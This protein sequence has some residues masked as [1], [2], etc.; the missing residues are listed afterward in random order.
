MTTPEY[1][2]A[3]LTPDCERTP[4]QHRG[5]QGPNEGV[6]WC[7]KHNLPDHSMRPLD[8]TFGEHLD[9]CSLPIDHESYCV[10]GGAG[11][12]PATK[13]RGYFPPENKT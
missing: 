5:P 7:Y 9:D 2:L 8:E 1:P 13:I 11:H 3:F 12:P 6:F 4:E 10:P